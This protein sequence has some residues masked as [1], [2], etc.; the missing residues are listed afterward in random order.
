[1]SILY[2]G[3][4]KNS[5]KIIFISTIGLICA[6]AIV[7][8]SML[9][10]DSA[11]EDIVEDLLKSTSN[12]SWS[13]Y[14]INIYFSVDY[15]HINPSQ[16]Q[17]DIQA[18]SVELKEKADLDIFTSLEMNYILY[19]FR[20]PV[21][22]Y[23]FDA[24]SDSVTNTSVTIVE[25]NSM[26]KKD[27]SEFINAS[28]LLPRNNS[29]IIEAF[30]LETHFISP[31]DQFSN[32]YKANDGLNVTSNPVIDLYSGYGYDIS[33]YN[34]N[35][36]GT[37]KIL[38][39]YKS[40]SQYG[41][42]TIDYKENEYPALSKLWKNGGSSIYLFVNNITELSDQLEPDRY[43]RYNNR[44]VIS[45]GYDIDFEKVDAFSISSRL[46]DISNFQF[47]LQD[48]ILNSDFFKDLIQYNPGTYVQ[49][50]N[51]WTYS[52]IASIVSSILFN[53]FIYAMP[54]LIIALLVAN[55]S[56]GLIHKNVI[57]HIGIYK[58]RGASKRLILAFEIFDF[59]LIIT[60]SVIFGLIT[61]VPIA[62]IV[63]KTDF[64]LSFNNPKNYDVVTTFFLTLPGLLEILFYFTISIG[65][66]VNLKR[67]LRLAKMEI[68][69]TENP[70]EKSDPYWKRHYMD[71]VLFIYGTGSYLILSFIVSDPNYGQQV[72]PI[73]LIF[74]YLAL[75]SPFAMVI[76]SILIL[77]R[78]IPIFLNWIG[79]KLWYHSGGLLAFS[80]KNVI[81]H[82]QASTRAI[83]LIASLL[84]FLL[85]F[86][87]VPYSQVHYEQQT[88]LFENGS[89]AVILVNN[90]ERGNT[91]Y[92]QE[93]IQNISNKLD[94]NFSTDL[95]G[96]SPYLTTS[97]YD[98]RLGDQRFTFINTTS[99]TEAS[100]IKEFNPRLR[101]SL[102]ESLK[103][104]H[105][106]NNSII[107]N[108]Q[109]FQKRLLSINDTVSLTNWKLEATLFPV[110]DSYTMWP[111]TSRYMWS[112]TFYAIMDMYHLFNL[113]DGDLSDTV[114]PQIDQLGF[115]LN[116]K[117][118]I[119]KTAI[120]EKI[121]GLLNVQVKTSN[122]EPEY[123]DLY[124]KI[125]FKFQ[126][127][128]INTNIIMSLIIGVI[129]LIMF[130]YMQMN[131]RKREI[132][133]ERAIG[134][135]MNQT[136]ILFFVE[137][138]ILLMSGIII[139][140]VLGM[141]FIQMLA[142]FITQGSQTPP[143]EIMTPWDLVLVTYLGFL[144]LSI[145]SAIIPSY[146]ITKQDISKAFITDT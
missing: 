50:E 19:D 44:F 117:E 27:L 57:R 8:S 119:N 85:M 141:F 21:N 32:F 125:V 66:I 14:D 130:A 76:G 92:I 123:W 13:N 26:L 28:S 116:F 23:K 77:N 96:Y 54:I 100:A 39:Y 98:E 31:N 61:G 43:N 95:D 41:G 97:K 144:I 38:S 37:G 18:Y 142:L 145:L 59:L 88:S 132:Y 6:I 105:E 118:G 55:Y 143:Y 12:Q 112:D 122:F 68:Y 121:V 62:S 79:T 5:R 52:N 90:F 11:K 127:G 124:G 46:N 53:M 22:V 99:Y 137:T 111:G 65:L 20:T 131:D 3:H 104:L 47:S 107:I 114:F 4:L 80:F 35:V 133:T 146:F 9:Y 58:T 87:S 106:V 126:V 60:I 91:T 83:M 2:L 129:I 110:I 7:S 108:N 17:S 93:L 135:K 102:D 24:Y 63:S 72:S 56:S 64:L 45:G 113:S 74:M 29:Q 67:T 16:I 140:T 136:S 69:E 128:Q 81:R 103:M 34:L 115:Y 70:E 109:A 1:M 51:Y 33:K 78:F 84:T 89:E 134:M 75:P 86:Y 82:R 10:V 139:G 15:P 101:K 36:T 138:I 48:K 30:A 40:V 25:L 42:Y 73:I 71:I 49:F 120:T 94:Q